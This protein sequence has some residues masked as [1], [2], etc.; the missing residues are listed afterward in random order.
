MCAL[1][2]GAIENNLTRFMKGAV[3][4]WLDGRS[5]QI[6]TQRPCART[7]SLII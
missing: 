2:A 1:A 6:L 4:I 3:V 7:R 5:Q